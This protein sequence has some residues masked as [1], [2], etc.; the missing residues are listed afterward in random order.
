MENYKKIKARGIRLLSRREYSVTNLQK[1]LTDYARIFSPAVSSETVKLVINEL[2]NKNW[3]S[4]ERAVESLINQ[5]ISSC[6]TIKL[7]IELNKLDVDKELVEKSLN[8]TIQW[9]LNNQEWLEY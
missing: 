9:T 6:G 3:V 4:D 8:K 2:I 5:K 7:R 1:K